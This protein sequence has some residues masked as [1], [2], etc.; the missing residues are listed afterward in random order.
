MNLIPIEDAV[1]NLNDVA[2]KLKL[3]PQAELLEEIESFNN[4]YGR[5]KEI[6]AIN[7]KF[8]FKPGTYDKVKEVHAN[9]ILKYSSKPSSMYAL[10]ERILNNRWTE[11]RFWDHAIRIQNKMQ[12]LKYRAVDWQDNTELLKTFWDNFIER[13][14]NESG[15]VINNIPNTVVDVLVDNDDIADSDRWLEMK[16][17]LDVHVNNIDLVVYKMDDIISKFKWGDVHL[18]WTIP[19]WKFIN[20]W[21]TYANDNVGFPPRQVHNPIAKL[22]PRYSYLEHPYVTGHRSRYSNEFDDDFIPKKTVH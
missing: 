21:C 9:Y 18:R 14:I 20:A 5:N 13:I 8:G 11:S 3:G 22:H 12:N 17:Y 2:D 1:I 10:K 16:I 4:R 7:K 6:I 19:I 15:Q